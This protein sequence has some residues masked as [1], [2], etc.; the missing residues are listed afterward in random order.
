[1]LHT[2]SAILA[3]ASLDRYTQGQTQTGR[4]VL[5]SPTPGSSSY[6][7]SPQ[8]LRNSVS[9]SDS[10]LLNL[11]YDGQPIPDPANPGQFIIIPIQP[12]NNFKLTSPN[13]FIYGYITRLIISQIQ[14]EYRVPTIVPT[15]LV[16][17]TFP[18]IANAPERKGNDMLPILYYPGAGAGVLYTIQVPYGFYT[19]GELGTMLTIQISTLIP[20]LSQMEVTYANAGQGSNPL[21][22]GTPI[23][24]GAI[25]YGNSFLFSTAGP[26]NQYFAFPSINVLQ[27]AGFTPSQIIC[28]LKMY[29][30][31]GITS[32]ISVTSTAF[33]QNNEVQ[34]ASPNFLYTPYIDFCSSNLTKFQKVKDADT[35]VYNRTGLIARAYMSS[36][37][38]PQTTSSITGLGCEPFM[39]T[40]DLNSPKVVRWNRDETIYSLDFQ[41]F[42]QYGDA[43]YWTNE[44]PTEFQMTLLCQEDED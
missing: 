28:V 19:P 38:N 42:D 10:A 43:L 2:P 39:I 12:G 21:N 27:A 1:M 24:P 7:W 9:R 22:P 31:V 18:N 15:N 13:A 25:G 44:C 32:Q 17:P 35:S 29:R 37:G 40:T 26:L 6:F 5:P 8:F 34:C 33:T 30:L 11:F 16:F 3:I 23:Q 20:A 36:V 4:N 14:I 41:L